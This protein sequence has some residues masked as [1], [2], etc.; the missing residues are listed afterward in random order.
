MEAKILKNALDM[1]AKSGFKSITMDDIA[2]KMGISKKTIYKYFEHKGALVK[3]CIDI[4]QQL[5]QEEIKKIISKNYNAIDEFFEI[6]KMVKTVIINSKTPSLYELKK[7]FPEIYET[8]I[9]GKENM[10]KLLF[11]QNL[12][13]GIAQELYRKDIDIELVSHFYYVLVSNIKQKELSIED[14]SSLHLKVLEYHIRGIATEKGV[15]E[16][17]HQIT[18]YNN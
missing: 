6:R 10:Y 13:K 2:E 18:K 17:E 14:L 16:L 11:S 12:D 9:C 4:K 3:K 7:Y 15:K 5:I 1:F 8:E